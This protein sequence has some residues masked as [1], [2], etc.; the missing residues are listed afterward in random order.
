VVL[1]AVRMLCSVLYRN[2]ITMLLLLLFCV[3]SFVTPACSEKVTVI[4]DYRNMLTSFSKNTS[5]WAKT[6]A[7]LRIYM[8]LK[9][10]DY[11]LYHLVAPEG[12]INDPNG[13][14]YDPS[15]GLYHRFYQYN[16][17]YSA[18]CNQKNQTGCLALNLSKSTGRARTWGHTVS[19]DLA[20]W[21][22]WPGIDA[23]FEWDSVSVF[24]GNC[25][26]L[27]D[28]DN[29][30]ANDNAEYTAGYKT[31]CIYDGVYSMDK[32]AEVAVCAFS[33]DWIHW[34]K[35]LCLGPD[36]APSYNS[37]VQHDTAIWRDTPGGTWYILSGG[38]TFGTNASNDN[39]TKGGTQLGN[40]QLW[41]ST[42][43]RNFSYVGPITKPGGPG[44]YWELPYLLPFDSE[45]NPLD[46]SNHA[47]ASQYAMMF[48]EGRRN[49]YCKSSFCRVHIHHHQILFHDSAT[50]FHS[51][52]HSTHN[53]HH[54]ILF[55]CSLL[56]IATTSR[57]SSRRG[58]NV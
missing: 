22:D 44:N 37:Q 23:D 34:D 25:A 46:N 47:Q 8:Q 13:V 2:K 38:C 27:D 45:G 30:S 50:I 28:N 9:D 15:T 52:D 43:L 7:A 35:K 48:G 51:I 56:P 11:P 36:R 1:C 49:T 39:T 18:T 16:K 19:K 54:F 5:Q 3:S 12:W 17:V 55:L 10:P 42:N 20:L 24:S 21:E 32:Y 31:V 6:T 29:G 14:T 58:W 40:G 26:I 41:S 57:I 4:D 33:K 53:I